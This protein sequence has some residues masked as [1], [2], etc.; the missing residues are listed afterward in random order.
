VIDF[1]SQQFQCGRRDFAVEQLIT[2]HERDAVQEYM[3]LRRFVTVMHARNALQNAFLR[4]VPYILLLAMQS[5]RSSRVV[6]GYAFER[7][8][9]RWVVKIDF[10]NV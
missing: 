5:N 6:S 8:K 7:R 9:D 10:E 2:C 3:L 4:H 1:I